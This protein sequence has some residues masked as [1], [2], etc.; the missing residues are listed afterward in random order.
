[1]LPIK[2]LTLP[3]KTKNS[4]YEKENFDFSQAVSNQET[5]IG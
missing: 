3:C 1:M 2:T 5:Y 4:D